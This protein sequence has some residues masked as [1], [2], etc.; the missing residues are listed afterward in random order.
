MHMRIYYFREALAPQ[1]TTRYASLGMRAALQ[2]PAQLFFAHNK[3]F[4]R[5]LDARKGCF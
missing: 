4:A 1:I 2:R 3:L 5:S